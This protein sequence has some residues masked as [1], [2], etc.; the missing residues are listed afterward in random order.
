MYLCRYFVVVGFQPVLSLRLG[1]FAPFLSLVAFVALAA[2]VALVPGAC[3]GDCGGHWL[4]CVGRGRVS[5]WCP[6]FGSGVLGFAAVAA[7]VKEAAV[8]GKWACTCRKPF[9]DL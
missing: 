9:A 8:L 2:F 4:W 5:L 6:A 1:P 3:R 7:D